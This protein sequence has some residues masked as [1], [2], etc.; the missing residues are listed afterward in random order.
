MRL[1]PGSS[2]PAAYTTGRTNRLVFLVYTQV[3]IDLDPPWENVA[4]SFRDLRPFEYAGIQP[5]VQKGTSKIDN[6]VRF[7]L[8]L[9]SEN[10]FPPY[11]AAFILTSVP[12]SESEHGRPSSLMIS[13]FVLAPTRSVDASDL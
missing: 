11:T 9:D 4:H 13:L 12:K 10:H 7:L 3:N 1:R 6:D 5:Q 8:S 2:H